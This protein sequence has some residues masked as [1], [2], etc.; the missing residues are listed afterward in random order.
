MLLVFMYILSS[1]S[2]QTAARQWYPL[3]NFAMHWREAAVTSLEN[4]ER[5]Q[6]GPLG[7]HNFSK[8]GQVVDPEFLE[9][10]LGVMAA[11]RANMAKFM[12]ALGR[13]A[14]QQWYFWHIHCPSLP[15]HTE[16]SVF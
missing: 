11:P 7:M 6:R 5:C 14:A 3:V 12:A 9:P 15:V 16:R 2:Q 4:F 8:L 1:C 13:A 10:L